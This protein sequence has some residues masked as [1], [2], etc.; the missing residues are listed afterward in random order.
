MQLEAKAISVRVAEKS[1]KFTQWI[2]CSRQNN[3]KVVCKRKSCNG[4]KCSNYLSY[5]NSMEEHINKA[6]QGDNEAIEKLIR[7]FKNFVYQMDKRYFIPGGEKEDL[8]QEGFIGLYHAIKTYKLE[9]GMTFEDYASLCIRNAVI[10]AIRSA[11]QKKQLVLT[12]AKS[13][14]DKN[15]LSIKSKQFEPETATLKSMEI[16]SVREIIN[17]KLTEIESEIISLRANGFS[18]K[19]IALNCNTEQKTVDN[20]LYRAR[21]KIR[22][23][24]EP[25][26]I[27]NNTVNVKAFENK[28]NLGGRKKI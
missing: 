24:L 27:H 21:L 28:A 13:I 15:I 10:R 6:Q 14:F 20:T 4:S 2:G 11:T 16:E 25:K 18:T 22:K 26:N 23:H 1:C 3:E 12:Q 5:R 7:G 17:S 8:V 9:C 19:E